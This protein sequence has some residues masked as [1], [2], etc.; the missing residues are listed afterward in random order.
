MKT[1]ILTVCI[2]AVTCFVLCGVVMSAPPEAPEP[3]ATPVPARTISTPGVVHPD[4]ETQKRFVDAVRV[5]DPELAARVNPEDI[6]SAGRD[7][8]LDIYNS[9]SQDD[10]VS[11][12]AMR[13]GSDAHP[14]GE[15]TGL[16]FVVASNTVLCPTFTLEK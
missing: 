3:H 9:L 16:N 4:R 14:I 7:T 1:S 11:R 12:T 15:A 2:T 8:C 5:I 13:L 10:I 6:V